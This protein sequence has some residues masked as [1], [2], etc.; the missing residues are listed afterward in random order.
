MNNDYASYNFK[1]ESYEYGVDYDSISSEQLSEYLPQDEAVQG[2]FQC[3]LAIG[4][5]LLAAFEYT[6]RAYIEACTQK[7]PL[8]PGEIADEAIGMF[9]EELERRGWNIDEADFLAARNAAVVEVIEGDSV[10]EED[11]S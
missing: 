7:K 6:L 1:T 9:L 8:T 11:I 3:R 10:A 5:E 4:D 2:I